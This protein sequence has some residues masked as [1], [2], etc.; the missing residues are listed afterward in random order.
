[1]QY[2]IIIVD[3]S[4]ID[5]YIINRLIQKNEN[6][7]CIKALEDG[8]Q[9]YEYFSN[10]D[11]SDEDFPPDLVILDINMPRMGSRKN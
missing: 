1:M 11:E 8:K 10:S 9:A 3:D 6:F 2:S 5:R 4:E 7:D